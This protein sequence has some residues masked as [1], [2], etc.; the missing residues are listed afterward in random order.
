[1]SSS[2]APTVASVFVSTSYVALLA[3]VPRSGEWVLT[4]THDPAEFGTLKW[5]LL[6]AETREALDK[7]I[8]AHCS[9]ANYREGHRMVVWQVQCAAAEMCAP[10]AALCLRIQARAE[11]K[12]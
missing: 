10:R 4:Y 3:P 7:A 9:V 6:E 12:E 5:R 8:G 1:M 11:L 2:M